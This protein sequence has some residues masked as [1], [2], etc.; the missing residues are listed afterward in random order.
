MLIIRIVT[1]PVRVIRTFFHLIFY[2]LDSDW[3][4][5]TFKQIFDFT[6]DKMSISNLTLYLSFFFWFF[7]TALFTIIYL[8]NNLKY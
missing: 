1:F 6:R 3:G 2:V 5:L 8:I 4:E 7:S